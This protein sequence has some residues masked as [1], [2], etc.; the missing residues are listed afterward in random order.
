MQIKKVIKR[1]LESIQLKKKLHISTFKSPLITEGNIWWASI[2]EN[3]GK[4]INGK[5]NLFSRPVLIFKKISRE[6]FLGLPLTTQKRKGTWYVAIR[7]G[8]CDIIVILA[9]A[10]VLDSKRLSSRIGSIDDEDMKKVKT[11]FARLFLP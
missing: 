8:N 9:Q 3:V 7:Q 6:T 5:S 11:G 2:G 1:F 4:E 10:R